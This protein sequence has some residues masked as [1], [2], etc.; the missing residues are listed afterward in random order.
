MRLMLINDSTR[1]VILDCGAGEAS[2][3]AAVTAAAATEKN[4]NQMHEADGRMKGASR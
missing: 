4:Y 3:S 1:S 2:L